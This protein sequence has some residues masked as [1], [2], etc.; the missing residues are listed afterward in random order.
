MQ[1]ANT[2]LQEANNVALSETEVNELADLILKVTLFF[3][4]SCFFLESSNRAQGNKNEVSK[5]VSARERSDAEPEAAGQEGVIVK[6][7]LI[8]GEYEG[9]MRNGVP[10]GKGTLL[11]KNGDRYSGDFDQGKKHGKGLY[12]EACGNVYEGDYVENK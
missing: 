12:K 11:Y 2:L 9:T 10:H 5:F 1:L 4:F 7:S 3:S 8:E 6:H